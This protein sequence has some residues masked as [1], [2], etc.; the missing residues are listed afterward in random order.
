MLR[1]CFSTVPSVTHSRRVDHRAAPDDPLQRVQELLQVGDATLEQVADSPAAGP[2]GHGVLDLG[3]GR[4][5]QD[6]GLGVLLADDLG[7]HKPFGGVGGWHADVDHHQLRRPIAD[8]GQELGG[9]A[10]L[11]NDLEAGALQQ[12]GQA[13]AEQHVVLGQ[14][15]PGGGGGRCGHCSA[16]DQAAR[17]VTHEIIG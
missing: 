16:S 10:G 3:M 4:Q 5:D 6:G 1:T 8:Q 17:V 15:D 14:D 7:R 13:L 12:A 2:Q 11:P 9:V